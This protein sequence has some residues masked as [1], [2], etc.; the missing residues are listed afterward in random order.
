MHSFRITA[1]LSIAI[2]GAALASA[3]PTPPPPPLGPPGAP[4]VAVLTDDEIIVVYRDIF[5]RAPTP[6]EV[7]MHAERARRFGWDSRALR[8]DFRRSEE[9]RRL[10]PEAVIRHIWRELLGEEPDR[11][12]LRRYERCMVEQ[13]WTP[14]AVRHDIMESPRYLERRID[15]LIERVYR[16]MLERAPDPEGREHYRRLLQR[17]WD[18]ARL[19]A[20][21]RESVEYRV[22][23]PD[24]KTRRAYQRILGRPA[25][26]RGIEGYRKR[27]VDQGW[28][29][30]DVEND[31]RRSQEFRD[32][33]VGDI[34]RRVCRDVFHRDPDPGTFERYVRFVREREL[35]EAE[36]RE[37]IRTLPPAGRDEPR[38]DHGRPDAH[39]R[40]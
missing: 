1:V 15:L 14:G 29:E 36:F 26:P 30:H 40:R 11:R 7:R 24:S 16:E 20:A 28:T 33:P 31:L 2:A 6:E 19:R 32:R 39:G 22:D 35:S 3:Q 10:S 8:E 21:I 27:L 9:Y 13:G 34:V 5:D 4:R 12:S 37:Q 17:G 38:Q 25:D 18:E 23:L